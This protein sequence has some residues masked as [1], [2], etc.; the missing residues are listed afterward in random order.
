M[1]ASGVFFCNNSI[2][3]GDDNVVM[4][5][6]NIYVAYSTFGVGHGCS[7]GSITEN[8]V[9]GVTVDHITMNGTTS[10]IRMKSARDRRLIQ[11]LSY[12]TLP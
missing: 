5:G 6:A 7:I 4:E 2:A 10:G 11:N 1:N 8:G 3:D 12:P 9:V